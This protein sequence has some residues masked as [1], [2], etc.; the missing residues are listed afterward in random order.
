VAA[1]FLTQEATPPV[2]MNGNPETPESTPT[3]TQVQPPPQM[4]V[5]PPPQPAPPTPPPAPPQPPQPTV[6]IVQHEGVIGG[7]G[8]VI[9]PTAYKLYDPKTMLDIDF[10]YPTSPDQDLHKLVDDRVI[11]TGEEGVDARWPNTPVIAIQSIEILGKNV[12]KRLDLTPP[13]QRH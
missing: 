13:K 10:L 9:A 8:S 12:I 11:V 5:T 2:A 7:V 6:R 4:V 3:P 1:K